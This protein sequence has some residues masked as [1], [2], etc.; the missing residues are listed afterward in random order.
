MVRTGGGMFCPLRG[1]FP[2][3]AESSGEEGDR[4]PF[5]GEP[6][7]EWGER[8]RRPDGTL[9]TL[10]ECSV[11]FGECS[12]PLDGTFVFFGECS[13]RFGGTFVRLGECSV[14]LVGPF[15]FFGECSVF[16]GGTFVRLGEHSLERLE[17]SPFWGNG[18]PSGTSLIRGRPERFRGRVRGR[19]RIPASAGSGPRGPRRRPRGRRAGG[20]APSG[21]APRDRDRPAGAR[22]PGPGPRRPPGA[23]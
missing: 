5:S 13:G 19:L 9:Q 1:T 20:R 23:G 17:H 7:P 15:V 18:P 16:F 21:G 6:F 2:N 3:G 8:L 11:G 14:P 22:P 10:G 12:G 4:L